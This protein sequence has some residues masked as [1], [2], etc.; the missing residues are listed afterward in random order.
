[1]AKYPILAVLIILFQTSLWANEPD[2]LV[3]TFDV[4]A[5]RGGAGLM[6]ENTIEAMLNGTKLGANTLELDLHITS[7]AQ[8]I[9]AH[10]AHFNPGFTSK[11]DRTPLTEKEAQNLYFYHLTYAEI[12][13]YD[14]GVRLY[15]KFPD[16][17][18]LATHI[19]LVSALIDSVENYTT[20]HNLSPMHYNIEIK[21]NEALE[22]KGNVPDY[23]TF[24]DLAMAVLL[25][26]N[27]GERLLVQCFD[28]RTLNYLH[29]KY[30]SVRVA[31]LVS[32]P[33]G[34]SRNL[35]LLDFTPEVYSP[36]FKLVKNK[37]IRNCHSKG[38][39]VIPWT[40]DNEADIRKMIGLNVDG[41]ISNYPN[42]VLT[43]T[44]AR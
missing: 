23:K 35:K 9:V 2:G 10:D 28:T 11:P 21:S 24:T 3:K 16:Q 30:P 8:V 29:E 25:S 13:Q 42:R 37:M 17:Q 7:D 39:A 14:T 27:L 34:L 38:I 36:Y 33:K 41:I 4:E 43:Q 20:V 15:P 12:S 32:N 18:K 1:M 31:F 5:H 19:P 44:R 6:P 40:V 26:K 22:Q